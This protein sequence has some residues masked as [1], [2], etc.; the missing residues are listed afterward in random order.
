MTSKRKRHR[1]G[2]APSMF[3]F[4]AVLICTMGALIAVLVVGVQQARVA[5]AQESHFDSEKNLQLVDVNE[6]REAE[7]ENYQWRSEILESKRSEYQNTIQQNRL[8][9]AQLET[10]IRDLEGRWQ[11]LLNKAK[12]VEEQRR[13]SSDEQID[14]EK[15][16]ADLQQQIFEAR[17]ELEQAR[18]ASQQYEKSYAIVPY[19]GEYGT[20]RRPVYLECVAEGVMIQ[21]EGILISH[22]D[23]DGPPGAGNPLNACLRTIREFYARHTR[24]EN[25]APYP[26]L[27]VRAEGI[28]A[29]GKARHAMTDWKDEYGFELVSDDLPLAFPNPQPALSGE[30]KKTITLAKDRQRALA[31]AMPSR[32]PGQQ[33]RRRQEPMETVFNTTTESG[34]GFGDGQT[35]TDSTGTQLGTG[36][37]AEEK[38]FS[39]NNTENAGEQT[40]AGNGLQG[41]VAG[42]TAGGMLAPPGGVGMAGRPQDWA[43]GNKQ[44]GPA[45]TRP[46]RVICETDRLTIIPAAGERGKSV[47]VDLGTSVQ[48]SIDQFVTAIHNHIA[49]WGIAIAGGHWKPELKVEIQAGAEA[50]FKELQFALYGSGIN[51]WRHTE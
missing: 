18:I 45:I 40:N 48:G 50:R 23:L 15:E 20:H 33:S 7:I 28:M 21:P 39:P 17:T 8:R 13:D 27:I 12:L 34:D 29:F 30:L 49:Q 35:A 9:L 24:N 2:G 4:L 31:M 41:T 51:V 42:Q 43:L 47:S 14:L 10:H 37:S 46:V 38:A 25:E 22:A 1:H 26:L 32:Y 3:P 11:A 19:Q 36:G 16:I 44:R 5:A 6:S